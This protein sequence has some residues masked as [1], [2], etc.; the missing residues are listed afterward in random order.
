MDR[1]TDNILTEIEYIKEIQAEYSSNQYS[2][3]DNYV[4][5]RTSAVP[6]IY[7]VPAVSVLSS[8]ITFTSNDQANAFAELNWN[9]NTGTD[10]QILDVRVN[11]DLSS[12]GGN[13]TTWTVVLTNPDPF[14]TTVYNIT[15]I[16]S[17]FA[18]GTM[19]VF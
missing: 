17:S 12:P 8:T 3:S 2:G 6:K 9:F 7:N 15:W 19:N 11:R 5:K 13:D 10:Q 18:E 4:V 16:V 1:K 14:S